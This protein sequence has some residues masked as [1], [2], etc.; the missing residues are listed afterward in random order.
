MHNSKARALTNEVEL[1][2][3]RDTTTREN[4]IVQANL[5]SE[6]E[7]GSIGHTLLFGFETG[8]QETENARLDNVFAANGDDQLFIP[9]SDP[10]LIPAFG[11]A[12]PAST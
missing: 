7:T 1:D 6:F 5:I 4:V 10:L 8:R 9:F 12:A 11:F 3:Y 2:G